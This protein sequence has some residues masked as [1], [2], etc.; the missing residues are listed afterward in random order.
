MRSAILTCLALLAGCNVADTHLAGPPDGSMRPPDVGPDVGAPDAGIDVGAPDATLIHQTSG[1][2][3]DVAEVFGQHCT[4][5]HTDPP[6]GF[7]PRPFLT[8]DELVQPLAS[9][10]S[11]TYADLAVQRMTSHVMPPAP[12]PPVDASEIAIVQSWITAGMPAGT[13]AMPTSPYDGPTTCTTGMHWTGGDTSSELMHP[14]QACIACHAGLTPAH[15]PLE[16]FAGTVYPSIHEPTDCNGASG[17]TDP[18]TVTVLDHDG[19]MVTA[20]ANA[21]GNF[22]STTPIVLPIQWATVTYQGRTRAMAAPA[23][24]ADCNGCH[25]VGGSNGTPGRILLP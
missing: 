5:C 20:T 22:S 8:R 11:M 2:P 7:A 23:A 13:C 10:P 24:S 17:A 3:C 16:T 6:Q 18:I 9:D 4:L 15:T 14:G 25:T 12:W 19:T 1:L 21:V